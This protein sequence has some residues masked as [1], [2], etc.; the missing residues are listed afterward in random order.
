MRYTDLKDPAMESSLFM[1]HLREL[2]KQKLVEKTEDGKY[3]L[4]GKGAEL[5]QLY[6]SEVGNI[7]LGPLTY[8][9]IFLRSKNGRWLVARRKKHPH[10]NKYACI[11]GKVWPGETVESAAKRE[12]HYFSNNQLDVPLIYRGYASIMIQ[13]KDLSTHITGPIWF[14]DN[15]EEVRLPDTKHAELQWVDWQELPYS[16]FI[17]GWKQIVTMIESGEKE[18][19]DLSFT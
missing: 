8:S 4:T 3:Q 11:S 16:E 7:R 6:S 1:Y 5:A 13:G 2:I 18:Y 9:L 10:I 15:V 17:P 19:L 14:A 12:L